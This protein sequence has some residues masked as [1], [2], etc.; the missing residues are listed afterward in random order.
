MKWIQMLGGV[1][2]SDFGLGSTAAS[3]AT[4]VAFFS[5]IIAEG[6]NLNRTFD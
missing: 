5:A 2:V 3:S 4:G 6:L 1:V